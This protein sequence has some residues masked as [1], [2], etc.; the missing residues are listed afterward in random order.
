MTLELAQMYGLAI[1]V[2][3][4]LD[5]REYGCIRNNFTTAPEVPFSVD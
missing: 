1:L 3:H 5:V 2:L 4:S